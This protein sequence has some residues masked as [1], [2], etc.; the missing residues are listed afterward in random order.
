MGYV[1]I[2]SFSFK[3]SIV[4]ISS[5]STKLPEPCSDVCPAIYSPV[6]TKRI[7]GTTGAERKSFANEC[8]MDNENCRGPNSEFDV[9][10]TPDSELIPFHFRIC[11]SFSR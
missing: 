10:Q 4:F 9:S 5:Y 11:C 6:C 7:S 8:V 1:L 3:A 2:D